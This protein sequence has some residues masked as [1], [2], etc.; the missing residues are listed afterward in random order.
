MSF[1]VWHE[2]KEN[3][4]QVEE[5]IDFHLHFLQRSWQSVRHGREFEEQTKKINNTKS[6]FLCAGFKH[7]VKL[8]V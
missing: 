1:E 8:H 3:L 6:K 2:L 4:E 7:L 5:K